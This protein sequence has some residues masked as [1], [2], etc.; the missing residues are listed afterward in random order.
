MERNYRINMLYICSFIHLEG[1]NITPDLKYPP[2][3][4][5]I[6][7]KNGI[8][9]DIKTKLKYDYLETFSRLYIHSMIEKI[10]DKR[11]IAIP[12]SFCLLDNKEDYI[13]GLEI[14][15]QL[16]NGVK[17][18]DGNT[19]LNNEQYVDYLMDEIARERMGEDVVKVKKKRK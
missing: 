3:M 6:D 1:I 13:K 15:K 19:I 11:R 10:K 9:I 16:K 5:V 17:F 14:I 7:E 12:A 18:K 8:A 4:C 2:R